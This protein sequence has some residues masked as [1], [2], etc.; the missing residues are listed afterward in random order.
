MDREAWATRGEK[1]ADN[2]EA[3]QLAIGDWINEG[4]R[5]WGSIYAEAERITKKTGKNL[6]TMAYVA[7][8]TE[9]SR[10]KDKHDSLSYSHYAAIAALPPDEHDR[11]IAEAR[12]RALSV[13]G[14]RA[15]VSAAKSPENFSLPLNLTSMYKGQAQENSRRNWWFSTTG[16]SPW[17]VGDTTT[18]GGFENNDD[19]RWRTGNTSAFDPVVAEISIRRFCP[20]GGHVLDP[21]A[22]NAVRGVV[23]GVLGRDYTGVELRP[24]QADVN[25]G[26]A[27]A[28]SP[29]VLPVTPTWIIGDSA[30]VLKADIAPADMIFSCPPYFDLEKYKAGPGDLSA[31][32]DD[33]FVA[34][35]S[36]ILGLAA[37]HLRDDRFVVLVVGRTRF[38]S[39]PNEGLI[40]DLSMHT[41]IAM[42]DA[43]CRLF[44]EYDLITPVGNA[45]KRASAVEAKT[46]K[47]T[48]T[49]QTILVFVKGDY[50]KAEQACLS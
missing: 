24:E 11:V 5:K 39:G 28:C 12:E 20:Q 37:D 41:K 4:G 34:A 17:I 26:E 43:G 6:R 13:A 38:K 33:Q 8:K 48:P 14:T 47:A 19:P 21:F 9:L 15:L 18:Y 29:T 22:G 36:H 7:R 27:A 25:R 16:M 40:R 2:L 30:K 46:L 23:A 49:S 42:A 44:N 32:T 1:L 31:M 45:A 50:K 35:Y 10:R 3:A